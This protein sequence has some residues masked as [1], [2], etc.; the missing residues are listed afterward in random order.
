MACRLDFDLSNAS[1]EVSGRRHQSEHDSFSGDPVDRTRL[2]DLD[3][4][5]DA[6]LLATGNAT[7]SSRTAFQYDPIA[8]GSGNIRLVRMVTGND[9][10]EVHCIVTAHSL[11]NPPSYTALSYTWGR[12]DTDCGL[13]LTD[14]RHVIRKNLHRFLKQAQSSPKLRNRYFWIDAL[15]ID[16]LNDEER[17]HQV[18]QMA[19]IFK[20]AQDVLVWLGPAY[21]KSDFA[22]EAVNGRRVPRNLWTTS[23]GPGIRRLCQRP[24]WTRL[25][26]VQELSL[27]RSVTV[28]C[29]GKAVSWSRLEGFLTT[30]V[31]TPPRRP[32]T[33]AFTEYVATRDSEALSMIGRLCR[34][35][36][37]SQLYHQVLAFQDLRCAEPRDRIYALLGIARS[38]HENVWPDYRISP[39]TLL[40]NVLRNYHRSHPPGSLEEV[41]DQCNALAKLMDLQHGSMLSF[42]DHCVDSEV[43]LKDV[44]EL[45]TLHMNGQLPSPNGLFLMYWWALAHNHNQVLKLWHARFGHD[46]IQD[47]FLTNIRPGNDGMVKLM[48]SS[49]L[50]N[51]NYDCELE[52]STWRLLSQAEDDGTTAYTWQIRQVGVLVTALQRRH[53]GIVRILLDRG[54]IPEN[55]VHAS[56]HYCRRQ[57]HST[58]WFELLYEQGPTD[59]RHMKEA[60]PETAKS[61]SPPAVEHVRKDSVQDF[62][63]RSASNRAVDEG[64]PAKELGVGCN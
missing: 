32:S 5:P 46:A 21:G 64:W 33:H 41:I 38:G 56:I 17:T 60:D 48:L 39:R 53:Y 58:E 44:L 4:E 16:Q 30:A 47:I 3:F 12:Y 10:K 36:Q 63:E 28:L 22:M 8:H 6:H 26:V 57:G 23:A 49:G 51:G 61:P 11:E 52:T 50:L 20:K 62:E 1:L 34:S 42:A 9:S 15:C 2:L 27:A 40:H 24:Y 37:H 55:V 29:G 14:Q 59:G 54:R 13:W 31:Q 43:P 18:A 19:E 25:W 45:Y 35:R 7:S